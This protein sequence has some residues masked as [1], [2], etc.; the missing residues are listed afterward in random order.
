MGSIVQ[1]G[2][3]GGGGHVLISLRLVVRESSSLVGEGDINDQNDWGHVIDQ[4][5]SG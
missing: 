3:L 2:V 5:G 1:L 4:N